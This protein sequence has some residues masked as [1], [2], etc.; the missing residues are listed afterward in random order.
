MLTSY[1][2]TRRAAALACGL[3][4]ATV[5]RAQSGAPF[6]QVGG[7]AAVLQAEV[8]AGAILLRW[9]LA[10]EAAFRRGARE[11]YVLRREG[12]GG[13]VVRALRPAPIAAWRAADS[14]V[15]VLAEAVYEDPEASATPGP[16]DTRF[17]TLE[18]VGIVLGLGLSDVGPRLAGTGHLDEAASAGQLYTYTLELPGGA[19]V[20]PLRVDA[21]A[22][23]VYPPPAAPVLA[24]DVRGTATATWA[25]A[26]TAA[27]YLAYDVER[28]VAP[29]GPWRRLNEVPVVKFVNDAFAD[30]LLSYR[31]PTASRDTAYRYRVVGRSPFGTT[32]PPSAATALPAAP[33]PLLAPPQITG[34]GRVVDTLFNVSWTLA[35]DDDEADVRGF[36]VL[37]RRSAAEPWRALAEALPPAARSYG[38][39]SPPDGYFYVVRAVDRNG[40][41][42]ESEARVL[43]ALDRQAPAAPTG[44]RGEI[45][46]AGVVRLAW[47]PSPELDVLGYRVY[48]GNFVGDYFAQVTPEATLTPDFTDTV[49]VRVLNEEVY[50][51]VLA[52]DYAGNYSPVSA[53]L[54]LERPDLL[55]PSAPF[56]VGVTADTLAVRLEVG[57]SGALDLREHRLERRALGAADTAWTSLA[58]YAA[59]ALGAVAFLTDST[60]AEGRRYDYRVVA[61]DDAGLL[62][63]SPT[64]TASRTPRILRAPVESFGVGVLA[65][66]TAP[67][68]Q[69]RYPRSPTLEA[70]QVYR[71]EGAAPPRAEGPDDGLR[72]YRRL[73]AADPDLRLI[74]GTYYF[75]DRDAEPGR[76][77]RYGLYARHR[78]GAASALTPI[79]TVT[80]P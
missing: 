10:D 41:P 57:L 45:D 23:T 69:W 2:Y 54:R 34:M 72:A 77:Y 7:E 17:D 25:Y 35:P 13:P 63:V 16:R 43:R 1:R 20:G 42:V 12:A 33:L 62:G 21:G 3:L 11:G 59:G 19:T 39:V 24:R 4:L 9:F 6:P 53:P 74:G 58:R 22:P 29:D 32:G 49:T 38:L 61:V 80:T 8:R 5:G 14:A 71:A 36:D 56:I 65:G 28:A 15:A 79:Q 44:L 30:T 55:P 70:F 47:A 64:Q 18:Y 40:T 37:A 27:A 52:E 67:T 60:G 78:R 51:Q 26:K 66:M 48:R 75:V 68:L 46:T 31:D 73:T 76:T 50:Y